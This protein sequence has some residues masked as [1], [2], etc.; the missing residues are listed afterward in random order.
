VTG[1]KRKSRTA[2]EALSRIREAVEA[3]R[4]RTDLEPRIGLVLGT[5]LGGLAEEI[6]AEAVI[7]YDEIPHMPVSTVVTHSG[8]L[9]LGRLDT[10]P[11]V[12][13]QG[14][15]HYYEGYTLDQVT[16]PIRVMGMLG[17]EIL[18]V[19]GA[20]GGMNP[21]WSL[22]DLVLLDDQINLMGGNPLVG[23]NLDELGP[24]FPD[25]SEPFDR[26]LQEKAME[27]AMARGIRIHRG[28]YVAVTGPCLETRAEYRMLRSLGADVVGMSTVPEVIVARHMGIRVMGACIITDEALPDALEPVDVS[29][30]IQTAQEAEPLLTA[31]VRDVLREV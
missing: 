25:M 10:Q 9:I 15:F 20:C 26:R 14:R 13:M 29:E 3:V 11:V 22:G 16:F 19:S 31:V 27:V 8:K 6:E 1:P 7:S 21:L 23:P 18:M 24:R 2:E 30:I 28:V 12:A 5:G 4:E 17:V